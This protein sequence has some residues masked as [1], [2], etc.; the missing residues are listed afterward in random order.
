MWKQSP[1]LVSLP[2]PSFSPNFASMLFH[3]AFAGS[4]YEEEHNLSCSLL[5]QQFWAIFVKRFLL[6]CRS[7]I[8]SIAQLLVPVC[9]ACI[10]LAVL[11]TWPGP[12][13]SPPLTLTL[14]KFGS[15]VISY[16]DPPNTTLDPFSLAVESAYHTQFYTRPDTRFQYLNNLQN[17]Q[18]TNYQMALAGLAAADV[19]QF[20]RENIIGA[21][22]SQKN[23]SKYASLSSVILF[24][25]QPYHS[26]PIALN[27]FTN[28]VLQTVLGPKNP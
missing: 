16:G 2:S 12:S 10:G 23:H 22:F 11:K 24:N 7:Y 17:Y 13:D 14:D 6:S 1:K 19:S 9:F 20:N 26:P 18:K 15:Q 3:F 25:N 8:I 27:A 21:Y 28:A 4:L 5:L